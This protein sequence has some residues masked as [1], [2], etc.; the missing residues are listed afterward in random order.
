MKKSKLKH[1]VFLVTI[2]ANKTLDE[3]TL[4][5]FLSTIPDIFKKN[6]FEILFDRRDDYKLK[7]SDIENYDVKYAYERGSKLQKDH[8]HVLIS[9]DHRALIGINLEPV[10]KYYFKKFG[11]NFHINIKSSGNNIK[12]MQDYMYKSI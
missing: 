11:Y 1:S 3:K 4:Q 12:N 2:N 7:K 10:R 5:T 8:V 6:L 9:V